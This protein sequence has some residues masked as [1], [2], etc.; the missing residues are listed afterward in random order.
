MAARGCRF[1][2]RGPTVACLQPAYVVLL[3]CR[4]Y[5]PCCFYQ[6][7]HSL[8][9]CPC[10]LTRC[11]PSLYQ[12]RHLLPWSVIGI[13]PSIRPTNTCPRTQ[14]TCRL[15]T[16]SA[17]SFHTRSSTSCRPTCAYTYVSSPT[18]T[19]SPVSTSTSLCSSPT[20]FG[21]SFAVVRSPSIVVAPHSLTAP[22]SSRHPIS[23]L[24]YSPGSHGS[25]ASS[26]SSSCGPS[27]LPGPFTCCFPR[28]PC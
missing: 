10:T 18:A 13:C 27:S 4:F 20:G 24:H 1:A 9:Q 11:P 14:Q 23:S 22:G 7:R 3:F 17:P 6:W 26:L 5:P 8:L 15:S 19:T 12:W 28:S 16:G 25:I 21:P 2:V